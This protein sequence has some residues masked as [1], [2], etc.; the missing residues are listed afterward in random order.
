VRNTKLC[1]FPSKSSSLC[2][3]YS[4][5]SPY[6][7]YRNKFTIIAQTNY[8]RYHYAAYT[9]VFFTLFTNLLFSSSIHITLM[10]SIVTI[11]IYLSTT[12]Y[13]ILFTFAQNFVSIYFAVIYCRVPF[14]CSLS[15][16]RTT[17]HHIRSS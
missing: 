11:V 13:L 5:Q 17:Q 14:C 4:L 10:K 8:L 2:F 12:I 3:D 15:S 7:P 1:C 9:F 6:I 16:F